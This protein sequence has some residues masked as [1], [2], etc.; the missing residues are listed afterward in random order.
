MT[1]TPNTTLISQGALNRLAK[2]N[3]QVFSG[4]VIVD[5]LIP[6]RRNLQVK[7]RVPREKLEHVIQ[8]THP[9]ADFASASSVKVEHQSDLGLCRGS[10]DF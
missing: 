8:K 6:L 3:A 7:K 2:H 5:V 1:V 9:G 10:R 4:V